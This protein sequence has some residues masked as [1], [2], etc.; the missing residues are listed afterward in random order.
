MFNSCKLKAAYT[1]HI[2]S[3]NT[4]PIIFYSVWYK[5]FLRNEK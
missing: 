2:L 5:P 3:G 1:L 4:R